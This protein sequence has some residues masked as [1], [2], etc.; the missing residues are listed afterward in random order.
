M[1]QLTNEQVTAACLAHYPE[2]AS[3]HQH[4]RE[5]FR[6]QMSQT[7]QAYESAK[8]AAALTNGERNGAVHRNGRA[9]MYLMDL[10]N[11][12]SIPAAIVPLPAVDLVRRCAEIID[13]QK[14][15]VL[16]GGALREFAQ[17]RW[18]N[19]HDSL[20]I[21]E[22][23]TAREVLAYL[24]SVTGPFDEFGAYAKSLSSGPI[25]DNINDQQ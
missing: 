11:N 20:Q 1:A 5:A 8:A 13:W 6:K 14:T 2:W 19:E 16:R 9:P 25:T 15:G 4:E 3:F 7:L 10:A 18:P 17:K 21:A 22:K 24:V 23:E 12:A